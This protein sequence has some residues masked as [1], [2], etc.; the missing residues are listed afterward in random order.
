[1]LWSISIVLILAF[2]CSDHQ[3]FE[4]QQLSNPN[5]DTAME[6]EN[7]ASFNSM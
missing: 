7:V 1:M 2:M 6:W 3:A 5:A 4:Q